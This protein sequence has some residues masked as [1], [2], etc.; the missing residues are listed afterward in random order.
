MSSRYRTSKRCKINGIDDINI[1][2]ITKHVKDRF[3]ERMGKFRTHIDTPFT[4]DILSLLNSD[5]ARVVNV[6]HGKYYI[7]IDNEWRFV[8]NPTKYQ[9]TY[10]LTTCYNLLEGDKNE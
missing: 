6:S 1:L 8:I 7:D 3:S 9:G 10:R 5:K 4:R 2:Y